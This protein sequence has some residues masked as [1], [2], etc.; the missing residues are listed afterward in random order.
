MALVVEACP[1]CDLC[2]IAAGANQSLSQRD[3]SLQDVRVRRESELARKRAD[4]L[5]AAHA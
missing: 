5:L 1:R 3:A 2:K 4:Q